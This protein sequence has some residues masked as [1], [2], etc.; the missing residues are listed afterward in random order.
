MT[1]HSELTKDITELKKMHNMK[2]CELSL[3]SVL[4]RIIAQE[5]ISQIA[6]RN[7]SEDVREE[8]SENV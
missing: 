3:F 1:T 6:L 2:N 8:L 5:T 4:M 7:C